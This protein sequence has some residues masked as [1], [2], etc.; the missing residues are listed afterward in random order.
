MRRKPRV[1]DELFRA[2]RDCFWPSISLFFP[3][4]VPHTPV[5]AP[6]CKGPGCRELAVRGPSGERPLLCP[7]HYVLQGT[8]QP[9]RCCVLRNSGSSGT[10]ACWRETDWALPGQPPSR[11][12]AHKN[13]G[14]V[15]AVAVLREKFSEASAQWLAPL[16][17]LGV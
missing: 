15:D 9:I 12:V 6:Q 13:A 3:V 14:M 16:V 7:H 17:G 4:F 2:I 5:G 10:L 11:C 8:S 1:T